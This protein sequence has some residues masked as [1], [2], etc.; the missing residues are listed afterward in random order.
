MNV[1][2]RRYPDEDSWQS[3]SSGG[4]FSPAVGRPVGVA[5]PQLSASTAVVH[6]SQWARPTI[7]RLQAVALLPNNWDQRGST[8]PRADVISFAWNV[9][10]QIMPL[11]G[12]VP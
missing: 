5:R 12:R 6:T 1:A 9:L 11:D 7:D 10:A 3:F 2:L 8:A 4:E